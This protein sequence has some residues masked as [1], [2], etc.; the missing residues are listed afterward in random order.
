MQVAEDWAR[1]RNVPKM[2]LMVRPENAAVIAFYEAIG[3]E[4]GTISVLQKWLDDDRAALYPG[5]PERST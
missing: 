4:D 5:P 1:E 2:H 3:Y